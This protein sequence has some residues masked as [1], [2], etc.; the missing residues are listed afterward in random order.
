MFN[1]IGVIGQGFVGTA[2]REGLRHVF[3]IET[4]DKKEKDFVYTYLKSWSTK[5]KDGHGSISSLSQYSMRHLVGDAAYCELLRAVD[6]PVF[7]CVPTPMK[8][9]GSCDISIIHDVLHELQAAARELDRRIAVILKSTVPPGTTSALNNLYDDLDICFNP[10]FLREVSPNED[11]ANQERVILGGDVLEQARYVFRKAFPAVPIYETNSDMAEM[12]KYA[13]NVFLATKVSL[14]NELYQI[15]E[16]LGIDYMGMI[17]LA[18][19]D[20]RLGESHWQVPA[21]DGN[22]FGWGGSCFP[23]DLNSLMWVAIDNGVD[24]KVMRAVWEKNL[25]VRPERDWERLVGRAVVE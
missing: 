20:K 12:I 17:G 22:G 19:L 14:A 15:C 11:F 24:P 13:T 21:P 7:V 23:K 18:A 2:V 5:D 25:E 3:D 4:Y 8:L 6:G 16:V 9:N 1:S 10:E